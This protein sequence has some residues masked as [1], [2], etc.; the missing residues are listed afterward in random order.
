MLPCIVKDFLLNSQ[1]NALVIQIYSVIKLYMFRAI[2]GSTTLNGY[3]I[4]QVMFLYVLVVFVVS[5]GVNCKW[6]EVKISSCGTIQ[7]EA[8]LYI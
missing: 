8:E 3:E 4:P 6:F 2:I 1:P 7:S 5:V